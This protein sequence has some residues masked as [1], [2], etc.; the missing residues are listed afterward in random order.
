MHSSPARVRS[1]GAFLAGSPAIERWL[2]ILAAFETPFL[3]FF[4]IWTGSG[5]T[6]A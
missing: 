3:A 6:V 2:A 1:G 5:A 4:H